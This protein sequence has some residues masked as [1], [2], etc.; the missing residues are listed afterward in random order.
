MLSEIV[1]YRVTSG[2][3]RRQNTRSFLTPYMVSCSVADAAYPP[4]AVSLVPFGS[5]KQRACFEQDFFIPT[6]CLQ[7]G[8]KMEG[9]YHCYAQLFINEYYASCSFSNS[10]TEWLTHTFPDDEVMNI[11]RW[12]GNEVTVR[13]TAGSVCQ[14]NFLPWPIS[15]TPFGGMAWA[16]VHPGRGKSLSAL[17]QPIIWSYDHVEA[18]WATWTCCAQR[19][20]VDRPIP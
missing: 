15:S 6:N 2:K 8:K 12:W 13:A 17:H 16:A 7:V 1:D 20:C 10:V 3:E 19:V 14:G 18:L 5:L 9:M 11:S 4:E